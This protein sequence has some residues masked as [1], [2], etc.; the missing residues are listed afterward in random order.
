MD[1]LSYRDLIDKSEVRK[2]ERQ[3]GAKLFDWSRRQPSGSSKG[4]VKKGLG[5]AQSTWP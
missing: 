2:V 4:V 1:P 5:V 3:R